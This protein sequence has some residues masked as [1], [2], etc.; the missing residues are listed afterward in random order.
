MSA[1]RTLAL[2]VFPAIL[3]G[4]AKKSDP[5]AAAGGAKGEVT[6]T[7]LAE[8]GLIEQKVDFDGSGSPEVVN[9]YRERGEGSRLLV[10]KELDLNRD[11]KIDLV[12]HLDDKGE[13]EREQLDSDFDGSFE[14]TD[15]YEGGLRMSTE[16]DTDNNGTPNVFKYYEK[17]QA[18]KVYL[19]RKERDENGDGKIDVW[20]KFDASGAV[21]ITGRDT[22]GDGK[23]DE[24]QE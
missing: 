1:T 11:G 5:E 17:D 22:D 20:E 24:R 3:L 4:C 16:Y 10:R 21:I 13:I 8:Q 2:I 14:W 12:T 7:A 15:H 9:Y 18:G 23:M 19:D 6:E